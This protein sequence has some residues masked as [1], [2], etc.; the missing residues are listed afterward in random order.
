MAKGLGSILAQNYHPVVWIINGASFVGSFLAEK[1]LARKCLVII[2]DNWNSGVQENLNHLIGEKN[3][4]ILDADITAQL[5][6]MT[7]P[8]YIFYLER[9][10]D[11]APES[12]V[13]VL[14]ELSRGVEQLLEVAVKYHTKF[15][16]A[17]SFYDKEHSRGRAVEFARTL[18]DEFVKTKNLDGRVVG[19]GDPYGPRMMLTGEDPIAQVL[20]NILYNTELQPI[21]LK[22][23]PV[24]VGDVVNGLLLAM[25]GANTKGRNFSFGTGEMTVN[26]FAKKAQD[27]GR[28][29]T[30]GIV[31]ELSFDFLP[32]RIERDILPAPTPVEI[33]VGKTLKFFRE[34]LTRTRGAYNIPEKSKKDKPSAINKA[35]K[36]RS[37]KM[38]FPKGYKVPFVLLLCLIVVWFVLLPPLTLALGFGALGLAKER[39]VKGDFDNAQLTS[40]FAKSSL[41]FSRERFGNL[42]VLPLVGSLAHGARNSAG[43]GALIADISTRAAQI[44][45][46]GKELFEGILNPG[47][48]THLDLSDR[49]AIDI[50]TLAR[51]L[52]FL[53][54][55]EN[56]KSLYQVITFDT[57][58]LLPIAS[59]I[60]QSEDLLGYKTKKVYLILFQNNMELRATGGFIGSFGLL[61]LEQGKLVNFE[62]QDVYAADGQLKGH[63]EPPEKLREHL[64]EANWYLRDSNWDPDFPTSAE[65]AEWFLDKEMNIRVDG[66]I[67]VDLNTV[68]ELAGIIGSIKLAD[69]NVTVD[70]N[71]FYEKTQFYAENNFFPG[72]S[73][74]KDFLTA[75]AGELIGKLR[76]SSG[77]AIPIARSLSN[78]LSGKHVLVF[79]HNKQAQATLAQIGWDGGLKNVKCPHSASSGQAMSNV[80]CQ[81]D[82]LMVVDS[83]VGVNKANYGLSRSFLL[84]NTISVDA[85]THELTISYLNKSDTQ[86]GYK[87]YFRVYVPSGST[88]LS[89]NILN[90][91]TGEK[92][93]LKVDTSQ[94]HDKDIFG[95]LVE[96]SKG[97]T[98]QVLLS[99]NVANLEKVGATSLV[100]QKQPGTGEDPVNIL[101]RSNPGIILKLNPPPSLPAQAG[102]TQGGVVGYN[103]K[104]S[105]DLQIA[106]TW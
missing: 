8:N 88:L 72:S 71:N 13:P 62:V 29:S 4:Q 63:V 18:V 97:Q 55:E 80:K 23:S 79:L 10:R 99:W 98:R 96:V 94:E 54:T 78:S 87:N 39:L 59:L 19:I 40:G 50:E 67:A 5:P 86:N 6:Q 106:A 46:Q 9:T 12:A 92:T 22:I 100:W 30:T 14:K 35:L 58:Q 31:S 103:T 49:L 21:T 68:K 75:V 37:S 47:A 25:F 90:P 2:V 77:Q 104:F 45:K 66:V 3:F 15:L 95:M 33:G 26:E 48:K 65:R 44:G 102:L 64:G 41:S 81:T 20:R 1:L 74:K 57:K 51:D 11:N 69:F 16:F 105:G 84:N 32:A 60:R 101:F 82:Y 61:T 52:D 89:A 76:E 91:T 42:E 38:R 7:T 27:A 83:N 53:K 36:D 28:F 85:V 34:N 17:Y 43:T 24:F 73:Q 70:K 56:S 93:E